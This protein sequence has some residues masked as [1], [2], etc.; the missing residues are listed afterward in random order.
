MTTRRIGAAQFRPYGACMVPIQ[1]LLQRFVLLLAVAAY[2]AQ[3]SQAR[4]APSADGTILVPVC[5][6]YGTYHIKLDMGPP[7]DAPDEAQ[8]CGLCTLVQAVEVDTVRLP[9]PPSPVLVPTALPA[10][11]T[12]PERAPIWPG[13]PPIGPPVA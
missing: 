4:I 2:V 13:A 11:H 10:V 8:S 5:S 6:V 7:D 9:A 12:A 3:G 1:K